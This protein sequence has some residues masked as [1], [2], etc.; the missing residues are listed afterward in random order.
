MLLKKYD[1]LVMCYVDD[2]VIATPTLEAHIKRLDEFFTC[3]KQADLKCKPSQCEILRDSIKYL[4][5][6]VNKHGVRPDTEVVEAVLTWK[7]SKIDTQSLA[8][9]DSLITTKILSEGML[10]RYTEAKIC[11]I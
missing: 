3:M 9:S 10:T 7:A 1:N 2:V 6:L 4:G 8:F 11:R 5:R